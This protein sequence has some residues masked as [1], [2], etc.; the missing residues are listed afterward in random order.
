MTE[1]DRPGGQDLGAFGAAATSARMAMIVTDAR[2][3]DNPIIFTNAA[4][5]SLTGYE[6]AEVRGRNCRFMQGPA[7]DPRAIAQLRAAVED[8]RDVAVDI[9]NYRRDGSP[10]WNALHISPVHDEAGDLLYFFGAQ[11]DVSEKKRAEL[12]LRDANAGLEDAVRVRTRD[13]QAALDQK[14][15]LLHEVDHRVKNNLQ[16][17]ASLMMLQIRRT[18]DES[19]RA[20]LQSMLERIA[21]IST[22]HR[23][24]FQDDDI[25]RFDVSAF[26]KDLIDDRGGETALGM[27]A[28]EATVAVS[29]AK[30]APLAI[31]VNELFT[32]AL[33][34]GGPDL[35]RMAVERADGAFRVRV[36]GGVGVGTVDSFGR[37]IVDLLARQL[38]AEVRFEEH[39][40]ARRAILSLPI[41]GGTV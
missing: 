24:L 26:L 34:G 23:R 4:F 12:E 18:S 5:T 20:A 31:I 37:E 33:A 17:I 2:Q 40:G 19:A 35:L 28:P 36:D 38:R 21:A 30:A 3:A 9:L 15:A 27:V 25:E 10:F 1:H 7:T 32:Y 29:A 16:L 39:D 14:T 6:A 8:G 11:Q 41:D 22:V 13:L